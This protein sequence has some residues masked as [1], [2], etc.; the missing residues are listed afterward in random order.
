MAVG[1][2]NGENG[3]VQLYESDD[4]DSWSLMRALLPMLCSGTRTKQVMI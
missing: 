1:A 4:L 2:T 3:Q